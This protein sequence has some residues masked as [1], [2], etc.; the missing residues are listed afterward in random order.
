MPPPVLAPVPMKGCLDRPAC[1][2]DQCPLSLITVITDQ[3]VMCEVQIVVLRTAC[4]TAVASLLLICFT[5]FDPTWFSC[6][7][8]FCP[9]LILCQHMPRYCC[10]ITARCM[11]CTSAPRLPRGICLVLFFS[12][13]SAL[14][15][16]VVSVLKVLCL[17][18]DS[19]TLNSLTFGSGVV[20]VRCSKTFRSDW[21]RVVSPSPFPS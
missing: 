9:L 18:L 14:S 8:N 10:T 13:Y 5:E 4:S 1:K 3:H 20:T 6:S 16:A 7:L 12:P 19:G 2:S 21:W 17:W 15:L 11:G